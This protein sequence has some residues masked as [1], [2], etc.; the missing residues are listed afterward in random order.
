MNIHLNSVLSGDPICSD[1]IRWLRES[2]RS[3]IDRYR[4]TTRIVHLHCIQFTSVYHIMSYHVLCCAALRRWRR[5]APRC[6]ISCAMWWPA[7]TRVCSASALGDSV[8]PPLRV[9]LPLPLLPVRVGSVRFLKLDPLCPHKL[10]LQVN[11]INIT[12]TFVFAV[13]FAPHSVI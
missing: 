9:P 6:R 5:A 4:N 8:R 1:P 12:F 3:S 2:S 13:D 7:P 10:F 11:N